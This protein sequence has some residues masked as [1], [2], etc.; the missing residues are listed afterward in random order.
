MGISGNV[1]VTVNNA[2]GG[3]SNGGGG[4]GG[5]GGGGGSSGGGSS[6]GSGGSGGGTSGGGS[7]GSG[8]SSG[9]GTSSGSS[10]SNNSSSLQQLLQTLLRELQ[11]LIQQLNTQLVQSFTR[12]LTIGSSGQDVKNLQMFL[13]DNG[14]PVSQAGAGSPGNEG[15]Y[16]G[17]KTQQALMRFQAAA[18][19]TPATGYLGAKTRGY[20][21]GR[22]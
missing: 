9:T 5:S 4:N 16:F 3:G 11:A 13:N 22:W 14:Y 2:T 19:I 17:A 18:G 20:M 7:S 10:S 1:G 12:N 15:T 8:G 6:G 21:Q